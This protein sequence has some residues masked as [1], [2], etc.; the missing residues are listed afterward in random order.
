MGGLT[1]PGG[2]GEGI[3]HCP[4]SQC[5]CSVVLSG[6]AWTNNLYLRL[7]SEGAMVEDFPADDK[8][9]MIPAAHPP[10][11][12]ESA[13][14]PTH[15]LLVMFTHS[16]GASASSAKQVMRREIEIGCI[17]SSL[18]KKTTG[19]FS[20]DVMAAANPFAKSFTFDITKVNVADQLT[21]VLNTCYG[22]SCRAP[23]RL[24]PLRTL[25]SPLLHPKISPVP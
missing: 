3:N 8:E 11:T 5:G 15:P 6:K 19:D 10:G 7:V 14:P 13:P 17:K 16:T 24:G 23:L 20:I 21:S 9:S 1:I 2:R 22:G 4:L 18:V 12:E 25:V